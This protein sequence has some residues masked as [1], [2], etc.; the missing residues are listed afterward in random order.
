MEHITKK[1]LKAILIDSFLSGVVS[2]GAECIL[3]KK[4]KN[5]AFHAVV[6]PFATQ[7]TLEYVQLKTTGSTVG[8]KLMGLELANEDDGELTGKQI[9]K[10]MVH[11]DTTS[12]IEYIR[13]RK[14]FAEQD[15]AV[16]PHDKRTGT[17]VREVSK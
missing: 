13:D 1:R 16:F 10:R 17:I 8:Y 5:E 6:L 14:K 3:R 11:R 2:Y 15:G 7:Y 12:T 9:V 4:I